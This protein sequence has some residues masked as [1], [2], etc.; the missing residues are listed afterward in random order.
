M[1]LKGA[2]LY[3]NLLKDWAD[4]HKACSSSLYKDSQNHPKFPRDQTSV[5]P[6][7]TSQLGCTLSAEY[8]T[9]K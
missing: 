4:L 3:S 6:A 1:L 7:Y 8:S 5:L 9:K 2:V